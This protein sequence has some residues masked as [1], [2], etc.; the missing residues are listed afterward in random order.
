M[1]IPHPMKLAAGPIAS[2]AA[3]G[4][5]QA[6]AGQIQQL[7][8]LRKSNPTIYQAL[9]TALAVYIVNQLKMQSQ[10][11]PMSSQQQEQ[12]QWPLM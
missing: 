6:S 12:R 1:F 5:L 8:E 7:S 4:L 10:S 2:G 3:A 11:P 9:L